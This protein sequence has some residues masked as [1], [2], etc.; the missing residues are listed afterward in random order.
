MRN[1]EARTILESKMNEQY[2]PDAIVQPVRRKG[3]ATLLNL[4]WENL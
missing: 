1:R 4:E 2:A 3:L